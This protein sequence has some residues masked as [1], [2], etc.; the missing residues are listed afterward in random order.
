MRM[1]FVMQNDYRG[2]PNIIYNIY[3]CL[4][5]A[6]DC[7]ANIQYSVMR[8]QPAMI[9]NYFDDKFLFGLPL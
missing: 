7:T 8:V 9:T 6:S 3:L 2:K 4:C 1:V 5:V